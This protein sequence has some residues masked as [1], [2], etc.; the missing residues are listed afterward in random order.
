MEGE[1]NM[2]LTVDK[3][4]VAFFEGNQRDGFSSEMDALR[5]IEGSLD[6]DRDGSWY[7]DILYQE[8]IELV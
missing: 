7:T 2:S 5:Y 3:S 8:E 6:G 4:W 1:Q